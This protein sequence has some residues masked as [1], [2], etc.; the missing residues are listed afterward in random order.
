MYNALTCHGRCDFSIYL[1]TKKVLYP[2]EFV[3]GTDPI[4]CRPEKLENI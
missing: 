4:Y 3:E 2:W 1:V